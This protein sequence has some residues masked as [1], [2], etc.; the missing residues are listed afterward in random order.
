MTTYYL[1]QLERIM[2]PKTFHSGGLTSIAIA[3]VIALTFPAAVSLA[4]E[5][6]VLEEVIVT[7][8]ARAGVTKLEASVS[9]RVFCAKLIG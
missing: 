6:D 8:V 9:V 1:N 3:I 5:N 2:N 4:Q 7:G